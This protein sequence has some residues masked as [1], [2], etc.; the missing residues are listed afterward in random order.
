MMSVGGGMDDVS[1]KNVMPMICHATRTTPKAIAVA[2]HCGS[3][4]RPDAGA[5]AAV[6][7]SS[8]VFG[9]DA[10]APEEQLAEVVAQLVE[11]RGPHHVGRAGT[12]EVDR[13]GGHDPPRSGAH[14]GH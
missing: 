13:D 9:D 8:T 5:A 10:A 11:V 12:R 14:D 1:W 6:I 4:G 7:G 2:A 3:A